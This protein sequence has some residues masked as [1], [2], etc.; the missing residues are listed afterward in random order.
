MKTHSK[1]TTSLL[2]L[3]YALR[4][5]SSDLK[6][7]DCHT[8]QRKAIETEEAALIVEEWIGC[9]TEEKDENLRTN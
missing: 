6:G 4:R 7:I 3:I 8:A 2:K 9:L 5:A 1:A